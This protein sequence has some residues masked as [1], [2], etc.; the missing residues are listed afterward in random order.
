MESLSHEL[1]ALEIIR[2]LY[3]F[4]LVICFVGLL[5]FDFALRLPPKD[6]AVPPKW[7]LLIQS[8]IVLII[9]T[10][11]GEATTY[12]VRS[13]VERGWWAG[14]NKVIFVLSSVLV[15]GIISL[16]LVDSTT[17]RWLPY[18][19]TW[20]TALALE[21]TIFVLS[22]AVQSE[23]STFDTIQKALAIV[24]ISMVFA[25]SVAGIKVEWTSK[26]R[27]SGAD[28]ENQPLLGADANGTAEAQRDC[29]SYGT[30][31][32]TEETESEEREDSY[33]DEQEE[34]KK[35][36]QEKLRQRVLE[37][38]GWWG[39]TKQFLI[40]LP[41]IWPARNRKM[42]FYLVVITL[43]IIAERAL[44]LL[45]PRQIGIITNTL[46]E[47]H[48][49]HRVP[50]KEIS[51]W[52][53]LR[54]LNSRAGVDGIEVLVQTLLTQF[55]YSRLTVA[56]FQHVMGLSMDFHNDKSSG[57]LLKS[58]EQGHSLT[59]LVEY[60]F[61]D[62][63]PLAIDLVVVFL[64]LANLFD[65]Y[66][67]FTVV[68]VAVT[69]IWTAIKLTTMNRTGRRLWVDKYVKEN[70]IL[71]ESVS[72]WQTVAYFNRARH[73]ESRLSVA[74]DEHVD[75]YV[76]YIF[77]YNI[78]FA[79]EG[80]IMLLGLLVVSFL[81]AYRI[82]EGTATVGSFVMLMSYWS[83]LS[84]PLSRLASCYNK[85]SSDLIDAERMLDLFQTKSSVP[86]LPDAP[87]LQV[88]SAR[89]EFQNV[90]YAYDER[91]PA[92]KDISFMAEPGQT[93]AL[94]GETGSGKSTTLK[95]L[96]RFYDVSSGSIQIDGQ[97]IRHVKLDSLRDS[98]GVVPQ[99]PSMFNM[100]I[101]ENIR[102]ARL[103]AT[104]E[105]VHDACRA[106]AVHDKI[107][108]FPDK[109]R[110][111]VGERGVKL[112]GGE[113]QRIAIARVLLKSP[114][115]VL[116][117][118]ATSAV[119]SETEIQI[120]EAFKK[121]SKGRTT[122]VVAHRLSTIMDADLILVMNEG[123]IIERGTHQEL[124]ARRG[125][126]LALWTKQTSS[127]RQ[128]DSECTT[129]EASDDELLLKGPE[130]SSGDE[131]ND[132]Q[133]DQVDGCAES[134]PDQSSGASSSDE[135]ATCQP[136]CTKKKGK[137]RKGSNSSSRS[138]SNTAPTGRQRAANAP[139]QTLTPK[140]TYGTQTGGTKAKSPE[141]Q[142]A[143]TKTSPTNPSLESSQNH[144]VTGLLMPASE[145]K[146]QQEYLALTGSSGASVPSAKN[147]A[148]SSN[149][150]RHSHH[151]SDETGAT[152]VSAAE[153]AAAESTA[154]STT[155]AATRED[156]AQQAPR[157]D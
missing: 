137:T 100:S 11:A 134:K 8:L 15:W 88:T 10:Y 28:E 78:V 34:Q 32:T 133:L 118:E 103:D 149:S 52:I 85:L 155:D 114:Q 154:P 35:K 13:L 24:R 17:P 89:V 55:A 101:M 56:A 117:D 86:D 41:L 14:Q 92:I 90:S 106:A 2:Q 18:T 135:S 5:I 102:Y 112:S 37:Q 131:N 83:T 31:E 71:Y 121:L 96:M 40:F 143:P 65:G 156:D 81:A 76:R 70:R 25:L 61:V 60:L 27:H 26:R 46:A 124:L 44:N 122:F 1:Q 152:F 50:W 115:M 49:T 3:P 7:R 130:S 148:S 84:S 113:L 54:I 94:V 111:K 109:Y 140:P 12:V 63:A 91:K 108:T 141:P 93:I 22:T 129:V 153:H 97:D 45:I 72:N 58:V 57:E 9:F 48:G 138:G 30:A 95:L 62:T 73:E 123:T 82:S 151:D 43:C 150:Q 110:S 51:V 79:V 136:N 75:A 16:I 99:D 142:T 107:M 139:L 4:V 120:Q 87:E 20:A 36:T 125:K 29:K 68:V 132:T 77:Y 59:S 6:G 119:D 64:Y 127:R 116:L 21:V 23:T 33:C 157:R 66:L 145:K 144:P 80:L 19:G 126:Y 67:A 38:G 147:D 69:Y 128:A 104:D 42:Q 146:G 98:M 53:G 74:I 47:D 39:Y 105:E